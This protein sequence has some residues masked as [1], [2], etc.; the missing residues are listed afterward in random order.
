MKNTLPLFESGEAREIAKKH[1]R[2]IG[3]SIR[4]LE[5]LVEAELNQVGKKTKRGIWEEFD[6]VLTADED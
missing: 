4:T 3:V 6:E 5:G 1:C 2:S